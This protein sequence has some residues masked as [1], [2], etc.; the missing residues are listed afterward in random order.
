VRLTG[1]LGRYHTER[2]LASLLGHVERRRGE[3]E[4]S[5]IY[6]HVAPWDPA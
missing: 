3:Y 4:G 5:V 2:R 1:R 6:G